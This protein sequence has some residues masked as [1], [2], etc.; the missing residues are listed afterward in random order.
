MQTAILYL[1]DEGIF[2]VRSEL[3]IWQSKNY[4]DAIDFHAIDPVIELK[5]DDIVPIHFE[6]EA[7][8]VFC[9]SIAFDLSNLSV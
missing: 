3:G 9:S 2:Y 1:S 8:F 5:K 4:F 7:S 6:F